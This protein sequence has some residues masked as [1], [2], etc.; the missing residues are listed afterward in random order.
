[1]AN[2]D[3]KN[4]IKFIRW[5]KAHQFCWNYVQVRCVALNAEGTWTVLWMR[6]D[7]SDLPNPPIPGIPPV[8]ETKEVLAVNDVGPFTNLPRLL[9]GLNQNG[10]SQPIRPLPKMSFIWPPQTNAGSHYS[11]ELDLGNSFGRRWTEDP[12]PG[13]KLEIRPGSIND[14]VHNNSGRHEYVNNI[15]R[16]FKALGR[17]KLSD[18][19]A[20]M[21]LVQPG[22]ADLSTSTSSSISVHAPLPVR[23]DSVVHDRDRNVVVAS[24]YAAPSFPRERLAIR[25]VEVGMTTPRDLQGI[26]R[27]RC[28][29][30]CFHDPKPGNAEISIVDTFHG[31]IVHR[32]GRIRPPHRNHIRRTALQLADPG[33]VRLQKDFTSAKAGEHER[34]VAHLLNL[35]GFSTTWWPRGLTDPSGVQSGRNAADI[36]AFSVDDAK[37]LIVEC[38]TDWLG[39]DKLAKLVGRANGMKRHLELE[40]AEGGPS[41]VAAISV[42]RPRQ[43]APPATL[44]A[45]IKHD[46][47]LL[48]ADDLG[49]LLSKIRSGVP[50]RELI[51]RFNEAFDAQRFHVGDIWKT[52]IDDWSA[53]PWQPR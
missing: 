48:A 51:E 7:L 36:V 2:R 9:L 26:S 25:L 53:G 8:V 34:G 50:S 24:V 52:H 43:D 19:G 17:G 49:D 31:Q 4:L 47:G 38:T 40:I 10:L 27:E 39:D 46:L 29:E 18:L 45:I 21:G 23:I 14:W 30:I 15:D 3:P 11:E 35:L 16:R 22:H 42:G 28:S 33:L 12:F 44:K 20:A 32:R 41:V 37:V 13:A 1:M 5:V 6:I